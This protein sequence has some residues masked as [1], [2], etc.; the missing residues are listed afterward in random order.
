[1]VPSIFMVSLL[2]ALTVLGDALR[3]ATSPREGDT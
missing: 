1:M 2:M 3:R